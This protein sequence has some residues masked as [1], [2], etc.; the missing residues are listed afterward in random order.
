M[1]N[2]I[3][4]FSFAAFV[5]RVKEFHGFSAP[6]VIL[7]GLLVDAALK[8]LPAG[9]LYDALCETDKCL[10]DAVQ[11]LTPCTIGNGWLRIRPWGRFALALYD[12][13][14][15]AG[16]RTVLDPERLEAFPEIKDWY[17]KLK[18]KEET[19]PG[20]LLEAIREGGAGLCRIQKIQIQPALLI[21]EHRGKRVICPQCREAYPDN[22][23]GACPACR[24]GAKDVYRQ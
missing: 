11:L 13:Q 12:K 17:Y 4:S 14:T 5:N 7:G 8:N 6:G 15:G 24:G 20:Q 18:P 22:G 23:N 10:P 16:F 9:I 1:I 2:K 21:R 19:D 3:G